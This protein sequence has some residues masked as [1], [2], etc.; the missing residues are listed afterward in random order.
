MRRTQ[1]IAVENVR[2]LTSH[3]FLMRWPKWESP[4][5]FASGSGRIFDLLRQIWLIAEISG[6]EMSK[7]N[8]YSTS[9]SGDIHDR[10]WLHCV[11]RPTERVGENKST[12]RIRVGHFN[13]DSVVK[14]DDV[15]GAVRVVGDHI[16]CDG[17]DACHTHRH[18]QRGDCLHRT[19]DCCTSALVIFHSLHSVVD[20][21]RISAGVICHGL[22]DKHQMI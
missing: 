17:Q 3:K 18:F 6:A 13:C 22:A 5:K 2:V 11:A 10:A 16:F 20:L 7:R 8:T 12:F 1:W 21:Q 14:F 19:H 9:E 4:N 15:I